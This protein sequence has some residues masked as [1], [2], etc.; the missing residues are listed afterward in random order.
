MNLMKTMN[1]SSVPATVVVTAKVLAAPGLEI[2]E[3]A[4]CNVIFVRD[5][6]VES[7][8]ATAQRQPMDALLCRGSCPAEVINAAAG[9]KVISRH[10]VGYDAVDLDA[11]SARGI[12]VL[13]AKDANA[14]SVTELAIGFMI[15]VARSIVTQTEIIRGNGWERNAAGVELHGK[16][17]GIVGLGTIGTKV[18]RV[19]QALGMRVVAYDIEPRTVD[20]VRMTASLDEL[21]AQAQV[22]SLHTSLTPL[23]RG[24]MGAGQFARLPKG[25]I[26]INTSRGEVIDENALH[27]ALASGHLGGAALDVQHVEKPQPDNPLR[28]LPNVVMTPHVGGHTDTSLDAVAALA[29]QNILDVLQGKPLRKETC[30]NLDRLHKLRP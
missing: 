23:T 12:P 18:A 24:M 20:G 15:G 26:V 9:L 14:Q 2:L 27:D 28:H 19:G 13:I 30:V 3:R 29:A 10:G 25:A 21:L 6:K 8:L 1:Q 22:L 17:L 5:G 16:T 11:A 4:G 7:L